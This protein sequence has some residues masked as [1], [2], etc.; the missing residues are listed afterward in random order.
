MEEG[1]ETPTTAPVVEE[2]R[3]AEVVLTNVPEVCSCIRS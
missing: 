2:V 3:L 1:A